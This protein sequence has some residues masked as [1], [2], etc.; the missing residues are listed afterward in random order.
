MTCTFNGNAATYIGGGIYNKSNDTRIINSI[1]YGNAATMSDDLHG[2][3]QP[4]TKRCF[5]EDVAGLVKEEIIP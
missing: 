4:T 2:C 1:V 3:G 5:S